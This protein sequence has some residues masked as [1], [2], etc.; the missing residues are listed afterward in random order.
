MSNADLRRAA[1]AAVQH[2]LDRM[3][4]SVIQEKCEAIDERNPIVLGVAFIAACKRVGLAPVHVLT[5]CGGL[6]SYR[7]LCELLGVAP[8]DR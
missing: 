5:C 2:T 8:E 1:R 4:A 7:I 3:S 6:W